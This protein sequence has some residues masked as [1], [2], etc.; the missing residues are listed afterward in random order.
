MPSQEV[1]WTRD[2]KTLA[3]GHTSAC[4]RNKGWTK[5]IRYPVF[6]SFHSS[7]LRDRLRNRQP[8]KGSGVP[9]STFKTLIL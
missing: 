3:W 9:L 4:W 7:I 5:V 1:T 6:V 2:V 8:D